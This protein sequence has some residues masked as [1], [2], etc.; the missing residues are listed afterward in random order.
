MKEMSYYDQVSLPR[1]VEQ[2]FTQWFF[3]SM[4]EQLTYDQVRE[5]VP[6]LPEDI[7]N[8]TKHRIPLI[9]KDTGI[10]C[11]I[12]VNKEAYTEA[13]VAFRQA[14]NSKN[15]E[16]KQDLFEYLGIEDDPARE[17]VYNFVTKS[18]DGKYTIKDVAEELVEFLNDY[19][20]AQK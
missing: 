11:Q 10:V 14:Q 17:L 13:L 15:D 19:K 12:V 20:N 16:F 5:K 2:E 4:G 7:K 3:Y 1:P 18:T 9:Q 6:G 8:L